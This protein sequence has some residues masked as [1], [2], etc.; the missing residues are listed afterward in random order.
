VAAAITGMAFGVVFVRR[1]FRLDH[2][3]LDLS[4]FRNRS[5][6]T[7]VL[8]MMGG[9]VLGS[10]MFFV[11]QY[12]Q[13]VQGF[14]PLE[15][16]LWT[17]PA[18]ACSIAGFLVSP[19]LARRIRSAHLIAGGLA[20]TTIGIGL[21][22]VGGGPI[23]VIAGYALFQLGCGPMVTLSAGM[24]LSAAPREQAGAAGA[25]NETGAEFGYAFGLAII[26][27]IAA[28]VYRSG[29]DALPAL[30][31]AETAAV[32]ESIAGAVAVA[33][34]RG[35]AD[36]LAIARDAFVNGLQTVCGVLAAIAVV[37]AVCNLLFQRHVPRVGQD[38]AA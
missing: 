16:A 37:I 13:L 28:A 36:I 11:M 5:F 35:S 9:T 34:S 25:V 19:L 26:G 27:T 17:L 33:D 4:L 24:V 1:Q 15:A 22:A 2:P 29:L 10:I 12:L 21:V 14:S 6:S 32:R 23:T 30:T 3:L 38:E 7:A 20:I 31:D 18:V 8:T